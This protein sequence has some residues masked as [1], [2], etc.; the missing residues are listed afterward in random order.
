MDASIAPEPE[1]VE[2]PWV[3]YSN[4]SWS[5]KGAGVAMILTSPDG[6]PIRYAAR[7]QF[8]TTN[9]MAEYEAVFMG[10]TKAKALDIRR[11]LIQM[12]SKLVASQVEKS[13]EAKE[14]GMRRYLET[15]R[16]ME[17]SFAGITVEHLPKARMKKLTHGQ[18]QPLV[19]DHIRQDSSLKSCIHQVWRLT[20]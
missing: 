6:V 11:L 18:S 5:H 10:L 13:F 15:V 12:D 9:N 20:A 19:G 3:M 8:N 7:L 4:G 1:P 14:E 17:K 16:S 2:Q